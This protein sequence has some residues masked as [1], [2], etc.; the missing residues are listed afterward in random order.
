MTN[1]HFSTIAELL[2]G[3]AV[4]Q[5]AHDN[6]KKQ[7]EEAKEQTENARNYAASVW[8]DYTTLRLRI[9]ERFK[10]PESFPEVVER[11]MM[12]SLMA[13]ASKVASSQSSYVEARERYLNLSKENPSPNFSGKP[14]RT[15]SEMFKELGAPCVSKGWAC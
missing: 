15:E 13:L 5:V 4:E 7:L 11:E 9:I 14:D 6:Y 2:K 3:I 1:S 8:N 12:Q 10:S